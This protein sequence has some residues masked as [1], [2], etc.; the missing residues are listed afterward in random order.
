MKGCVP[1]AVCMQR[2]EFECL[3]RTVR[4]VQIEYT[5]LY[6]KARIENL[7]SGYCNL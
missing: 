5:V 6:C 2:F 7:G 1:N 3:R 4:R